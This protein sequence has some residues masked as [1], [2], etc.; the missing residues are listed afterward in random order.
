MD[1]EQYPRSDID[2]YSV[3]HTRH[4]INCK[5]LLVTLL[6]LFDISESS[7]NVHRKVMNLAN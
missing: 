3:R 5:V 1:D 2:V 6:S 7:S 4:R